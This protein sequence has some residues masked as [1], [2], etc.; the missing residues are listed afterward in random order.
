MVSIPT[1][2]DARTLLQAHMKTIYDMVEGTIADCSQEAANTWRDGW[3]A[4]P[5][6]VIYLHALCSDD[7]MVNEVA[8]GGARLYEAGGWQ[9]RLGAVNM[10]YMEG[11]PPGSLTLDL[12]VVREYGAAVRAATDQFLANATEAEL[13][14]LVGNHS[15]GQIPVAEYLATYLGTHMSE[16]CGEIAALKGVLGLKGLPF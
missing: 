4:Q 8:R 16:H 1:R 5:I 7:Y 9:E 10:L 13:T 2:I 3:T 14:R 6:S 12:N 11:I 15:G